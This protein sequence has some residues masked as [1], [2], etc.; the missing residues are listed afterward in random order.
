MSRT[1][2][3]SRP[4]TCI[5]CWKWNV[6]SRQATH[7]SYNTCST[8]QDTVLA[9]CACLREL[10]EHWHWKHSSLF[11]CSC[12]HGSLPHQQ[13]RQ[14]VCCTSWRAAAFPTHPGA[15]ISHARS[16]CLPSRGGS[17]FGIAS[18]GTG[19]WK[20]NFCLLLEPHTLPAPIP[21]PQLVLPSLIGHVVCSKM[22]L[23]QRPLEFYIG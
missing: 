12:I 16:C 9:C 10:E 7:R 1:S 21:H 5:W 8:L 13:R 11:T 20:W 18:W 14:A 3:N 22:L 17:F 6:I 15:Q 4:W 19:A 23:S 2:C